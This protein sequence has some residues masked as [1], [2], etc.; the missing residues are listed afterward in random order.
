MIDMKTFTKNVIGSLFIVMAIYGILFMQRAIDEAYQ[1]HGL[2]ST[3][4]LVQYQAYAILP[5]VIAAILF[6]IGITILRK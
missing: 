2:A 4:A 1:A 3:T 6:G 5:I